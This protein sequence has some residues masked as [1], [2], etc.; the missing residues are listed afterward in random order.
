M[1]L[2]LLLATALLSLLRCSML[3]VECS[4]FASHAI[5]TS[6]TQHRTSHVELEKTEKQETPIT[7]RKKPAAAVVKTFDPR[8]R[9]KDMPALR[10]D[11]AAVTETGFA[12]AVQIEVESTMGSDKSVTTKIVGIR[13]DIRLDITEWLPRNATKKIRD[14]ED[15]H[16]IIS[17][18]FYTDA[19]T[20]A[21]DLAK[22]LIGKQ[23]DVKS[24]DDIQ[25][26][27]K[28]AA[29]E[30]CQAYLSAIEAPSQK[31]QEKFDQL[32]DHG[33]NK[34]PEK[35]AVQEALDSVKN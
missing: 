8:N 25:P 18:H 31:A 3:D 17:E 32:T 4:M 29:T 12:C 35:R 22:P 9:P 28:K 19:Q 24:K 33:R 27:I 2:P 7:I 5:G 1:P 15:A 23:L 16:R 21:Q 13:T 26:A 20:V 14:H 10:K 6:N 11:E 30:Y 34:V